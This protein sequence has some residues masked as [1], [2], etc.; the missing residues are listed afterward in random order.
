M[1]KLTDTQRELIDTV[2]RVVQKEI[3]PI[4]REILYLSAPG[5]GSFSRC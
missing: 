2:R 5:S 4:A 1:L 3:A